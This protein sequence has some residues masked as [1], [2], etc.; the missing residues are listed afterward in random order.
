MSLDRKDVKVYFD[1][2]LH[3]AIKVICSQRDTTMAEFIEALVV[4]EVHAVVHDVTM[5]ADEFRRTGIVRD[6][7]GA[8]GMTRERQESP[9]IA[10]NGPGLAGV[11]RAG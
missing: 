3:A 6:L 1:H 8:S 2:A 5:L 4:R 7:P 11:E 9:G 10:R